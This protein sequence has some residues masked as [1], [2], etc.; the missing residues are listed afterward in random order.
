MIY[1]VIY[2]ITCTINNKKYV[3]QTIRNLEERWRDHLRHT[4]NPKTYLHRAMKKEG[5]ENFIIEK[6]YECSSQE[7]LNEK[8]KYF[9]NLYEAWAPKGYT[10]KAGNGKGAC[11]EETRK[12]MSKSSTGKTHSEETKRQLSLNRKGKHLGIDNP[13]YGKCHSEETRKK[14]SD[15][16]KGM[17]HSEKT[18][19]L[20]SQ[21]MK[22]ENN[23]FYGK[24]HLQ[25][26]IEKIRKSHVKKTY[27]FRSPNGSFVSVTNLRQ[28][29]RENILN[30]GTMYQ[31]AKGK[32][33]QHKGWTKD[34]SQGE[35][36]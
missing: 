3:G 16:H 35:E 33:L 14:M 19:T 23:P 36:K 26:S 18:K 6:I 5:L 2:L 34:L 30:N 10:C 12:K 27:Y 1:G 32:I 11:S 8:E 4:K 13:F 29:C 31:V 22:G 21:K 7:E 15:I 28:F 25:S 20:L 24:K 17:K 9:T